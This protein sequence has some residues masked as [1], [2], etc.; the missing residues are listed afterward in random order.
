MSN[1]KLSKSKYEVVVIGVS[2]GGLEALLQIIPKLPKDFELPII[3]VNH[4]LPDAD[5]FL[6]NFLNEKSQLNVMEAM[7]KERINKGK[8]Y[9]APA[10]YHL[11]VEPDK[12]LSLS[13]DPP[14][15]HSRP[16]VDILFETAAY[17][18]SGK[19]IGVVLTG[20]NFD[21]TIGLNKI[22]QTGGLTIVQDPQTA[23][24]KAMPRSAIDQVN[25]HHIIPL[26]KIA[27]FIVK[28]CTN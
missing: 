2:S 4:M 10:N 18:Y 9:L 8:V 14:L 1:E 25:P 26:N 6:V 16:S 28:L 22:K 12:T 21:G 15:N 23:K 13:V 20:A 19:L 7:E 17:A 5:N 11:L 27:S 3:I 24:S